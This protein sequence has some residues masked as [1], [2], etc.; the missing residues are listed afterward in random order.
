MIKTI[1]A[2]ENK[3]NEK[4]ELLAKLMNCKKET[5]KKIL[6]AGE[7]ITITANL[8]TRTEKL[9]IRVMA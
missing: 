7:E 4:I 2:K 6:D 3:I 8:F 1:E 5:I 9:N